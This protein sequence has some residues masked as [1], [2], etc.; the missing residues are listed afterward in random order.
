MPP[1]PGNTLRTGSGRSVPRCPGNPPNPR[2][3]E[4]PLTRRIT[5]ALTA[6]V[7]LPV[8][9]VLAQDRS[10]SRSMVSSP[11]GVVASESALA[12]QVGASILG[13]GGNAA[14]A[15]VRTNAMMGLV[16]P[17]SNGIG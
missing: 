3:A 4:A 17:M 16:G 12:S 1:A 6:I 14:V 5:L 8:S 10:Q 13:Q 11:S 7:M 2:H 9:E 15:A